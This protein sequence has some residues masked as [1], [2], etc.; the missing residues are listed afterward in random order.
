MWY[1]DAAP[2]LRIANLTYFETRTVAGLKIVDETSADPG[3]AG[4]APVAVDADHVG[5]AKARSRTDQIFLGV[6]GFLRE[7]LDR[8]AAAP[9][10]VKVRFQVRA[11]DG[12]S[13]IDV[14]DVKGAL[15]GGAK[16]RLQLTNAGRDNVVV[17]AMRLQ[18]RHA[19]PP[20]VVAPPV[21]AAALRFGDARVPHQLYLELRGTAWNGRW[22]VQM[23][24]GTAAIRTIEDGL[25][26]LLDTD[27]PTEFDVAPGST[28]SITGSFSTQ[29]PGVYIVRLAI[30]V[31]VAGTSAAPLVTEPLALVQFTPT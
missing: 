4:S 26:N 5:I 29:E 8:H 19:A 13:P 12:R 23:P 25:D 22:V 18:V 2:A 30:D 15:P 17:D 21:A 3:I 31:A 24:N 16:F 9:S 11:L 10:P 1:R 6:V 20:S 27:P 7:C 14:G 28:E